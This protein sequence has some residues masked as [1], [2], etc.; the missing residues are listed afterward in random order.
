MSA[1]LSRRGF[2][3]GRTFDV[4]E[5][6][7]STAEIGSRCFARRDIACQLCRDVCETDAIRFSL[8]LGRVAVPLVDPD[9]CTA[10][11][12]CVPVCP[13]S[14]ITVGAGASA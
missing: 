14:A 4:S 12:E 13:V 6:I 1:S 9:R 11:G 8:T 7:A 2:L 10:C 5:P 3:L